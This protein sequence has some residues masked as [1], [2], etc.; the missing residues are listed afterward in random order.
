M[1]DQ[2]GNV[3]GVVVAKLDAAR[4]AS[5]IGDIRQNVNFAIKGR[6]VAAFL[7]RNKLKPILSAGSKR[8]TTEAVAAAASSFTVRIICHG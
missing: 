5:I 1:L 2:S 6:E 7:A 4:A 3:V 8:L